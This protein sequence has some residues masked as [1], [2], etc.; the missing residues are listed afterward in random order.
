MRYWKSYQEESGQPSGVY[1]FRAASDEYDSK[2]YS[3]VAD[4][5]IAK[6]GVKSEFVVYFQGADNTE[7]D[8]VVTISIEDLAVL[9]YDVLLYSLPNTKLTGHEV[10][11]NFFAPNIKNNGVFYTDSNALEM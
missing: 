7:G 3:R 8:A 10:T 4:V 2:V 9:K 6:S 11:A 5:K 1:I